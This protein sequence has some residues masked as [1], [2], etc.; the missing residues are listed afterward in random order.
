MIEDS[1]NVA[2][3]LLASV[4]TLAVL[5]MKAVLGREEAAC[6]PGTFSLEIGGN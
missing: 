1:S 3:W 6:E 2:T 4:G 5:G